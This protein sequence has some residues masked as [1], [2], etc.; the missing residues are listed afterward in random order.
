MNGKTVLISFDT[1]EILV[2]LIT[3]NPKYNIKGFV[4]EVI[5]KAVKKDHPQ[6][7]KALENRNKKKAA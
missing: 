2:E 4:D 7:V 6:V 3:Q 5:L 1:H